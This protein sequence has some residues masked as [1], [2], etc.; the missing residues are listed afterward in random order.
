MYGYGICYGILALIGAAMIWF[1]GVGVFAGRAPAAMPGMGSSGGFIGVAIGVGCAAVIT[2]I[3]SLVFYILY[4][5]RLGQLS[6]RLRE[7]AEIARYVW[8]A[9]ANVPAALPAPPPLDNPPVAPGA[10]PAAV[11]RAEATPAPQSAT[12]LQGDDRTRTFGPG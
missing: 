7:Q 2:G 4:L 5:V 8:S 6:G 10:G 12:L 3:A 9:A 1:M 11:A